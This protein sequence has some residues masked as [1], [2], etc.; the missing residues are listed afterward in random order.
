MLAGVKL[1]FIVRGRRNLRPEF[2]RFPT[3]NPRMGLPSFLYGLV[4]VSFM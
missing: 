4:D 3:P 1:G 2:S